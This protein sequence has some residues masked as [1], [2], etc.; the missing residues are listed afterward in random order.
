MALRLRQRAVSRL[1]RHQLTAP[2][3]SAHLR[4][5]PFILQFNIVQE[6]QIIHLSTTWNSETGRSCSLIKLLDGDS[7]PVSNI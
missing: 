4:L 1:Q 6:S 5:Q 2:K 3:A 7:P